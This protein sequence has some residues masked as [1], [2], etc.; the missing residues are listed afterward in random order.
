[1]EQSQA[2]AAA[3]AAPT[4]S[5]PKTPT[6]AYEAAMAAQ[7]AVKGNTTAENVAPA[8]EATTSPEPAAT[9]EAPTEPKPDDKVASKFAALSRK[10]KLVSQREKALAAREKE[11]AAKEAAAGNVDAAKYID[12]AEFK[13]NPYKYMK[14]N[15]LTLEQVAEIALNDGKIT[16]EKLLQESESKMEAKLKAMEEKL[17]AKEEQ[18][19]Q[20][21]V[22][23]QLQEFKTNLGKFVTD[24]PEYEMIQSQGPEGVQLVY[25]VI[26]IHYEQQVAAYVEENGEQPDYDTKQTFILPNKQAS[27]MVEQHLLNQEKARIEKLRKLS[28]T[29]SLFEAPAPATQSVKAP[30][31]TLTNTQA[32]TVPQSAAT[33][34]TEDEQKAQIA[35]MIKFID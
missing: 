33:K 27:D 19:Q 1:M 22:D 6:E 31:Q 16:S 2:P 34:L 5:A 26:E 35:K 17:A 32:S 28:K 15:G 8:V 10:E 11:L 24:T 9:T 18:E 25:D 14:D 21:N 7:E 30:S 20:Q 29:K 3:A 13:R 4:P 23:R 12:V